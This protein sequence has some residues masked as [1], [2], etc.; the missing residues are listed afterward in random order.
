M[1]LTHSLTSYIK[2][3]NDLS[4]EIKLI[5]TK[6]LIKDLVNGY[7]FLMMQ[8]IT[9]YDSQNHFCFNHYTGNL[10]HYVMAILFQG[11]SKTFS[12]NIT[13]PTATLSLNPEMAY[14]NDTSLK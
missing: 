7:I 4:T 2:L 13:K 9:E 5:L 11:K 14:T 3:I 1:P 8:N 10:K 6:E 12:N